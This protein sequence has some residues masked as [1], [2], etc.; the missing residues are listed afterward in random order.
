MS[1]LGIV[2][3]DKKSV[4]SNRVRIDQNSGLVGSGN[5]V[6]FGPTTYLPCL[7]LMAPV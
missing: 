4:M 5:I 6:F 7:Y 2:K 3:L 1:K